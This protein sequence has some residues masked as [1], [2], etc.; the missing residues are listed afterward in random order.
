MIH[1]VHWHRSHTPAICQLFFDAYRLDRN[2][3][4]T[5]KTSRE[6]VHALPISPIYSFTAKDGDLIVGALL[7][8]QKTE[9]NGKELF[10]DEIIV[11]PSYQKQGIGTRLWNQTVAQARKRKLDGIR[12]ETKEKS[13]ATKWYQNLGLKPSGWIEMEKTL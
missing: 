12:L 11:D 10:I 7:A 13:R 9:E 6:Y 8:Y 1:I 3:D 2:A 4:W 5:E